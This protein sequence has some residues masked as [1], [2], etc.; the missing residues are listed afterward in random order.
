MMP[1]LKAPLNSSAAQ[2][3]MSVDDATR[4][5]VVTLFDQLRGVEYAT[6]ARGYRI[7]QL[8]P[9]HVRVVPVAGE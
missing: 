6:Y 1:Q 8:G 9:E 3:G 5:E 4:L 2:E 7:D